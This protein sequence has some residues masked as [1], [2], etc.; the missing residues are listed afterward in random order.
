MSIQDFFTKHPL[1][2]VVPPPHANDEYE[3]T[4]YVSSILFEEARFDMFCTECKSHS[5]FKKVPRPYNGV[6]KSFGD[7]KYTPA[8]ANDFY[9]IKAICSRNEQH[10]AVIYL[11][12][13][14]LNLSKVGQFPALADILTPDLK[15]YKAAIGESRIREWTRA[16]G[17]SSHG[18]GAGAFVYLRRIL[19]SLIEEAH[20]NASKLP[21]WDEGKYIQSRITERIDL[22]SSY[23]PSFIVE[24]K[25]AYSILSCQDP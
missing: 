2:Q 8:L 13:Q 4:L 18:I 19:E 15:R 6:L 21:S 25:S 20:Q 12:L 7:N 9:Q 17:L 5:V 11:Q 10:D 16:V 23:L 3:N 24:N 14:D 22:L 1:Y